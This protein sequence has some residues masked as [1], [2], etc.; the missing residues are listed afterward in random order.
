MLVSTI[1]RGVHRHLPIDQLSGISL[2]EQNAKDR[3]PGTIG[4]ETAVALPD[5]LPRPE[6]L[7]KVTPWNPRT[8]PVDDSFNCPSVFVEGAAGSTG[9]IWHERGQ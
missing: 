7:R 1:D 6:M 4:T 5:G 3:V 2:G 9:G 8:V